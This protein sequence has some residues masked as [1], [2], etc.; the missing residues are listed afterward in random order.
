MSCATG[1]MDTTGTVRLLQVAQLCCPHD[2]GSAF[3][4]NMTKPPK[5]KLDV[6]VLGETLSSGRE[7]FKLTFME[8]F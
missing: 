5:P 7:T 4:W 8:S 2:R 6:C 1:P 3:F